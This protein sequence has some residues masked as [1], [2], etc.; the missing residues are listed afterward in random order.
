MKPKIW[1]QIHTILIW[2][3]K[4]VPNFS[5]SILKLKKKW[6]NYGKKKSTSKKH[7]NP[8]LTNQ[9]N[10]PNS[11]ENAY[12][13]YFPLISNTDNLYSILKC[14]GRK[15]LSNKSYKYVVPSNT[16]CKVNTIYK[17]EPFEE[18]RIL[19]V[20][21]IELLVYKLTKKLLCYNVKY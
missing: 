4:S 18:I 20:E 19:W 10:S 21:H 7:G 16:N 11:L 15:Q 6:S 13:T 9:E 1:I 17:N 5:N 12:K 8:L 2:W 3:T 14:L